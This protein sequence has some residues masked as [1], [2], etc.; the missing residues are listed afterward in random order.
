MYTKKSFHACQFNPLC[1]GPILDE[2]PQLKMLFVRTADNADSLLRYIIMVYDPKS[3]M[4]TGER[5]VNKRKELAA[6]MASLPDDFDY[7]FM[8]EIVTEYL[9]TFS[10]SKEWAAIC[11][12]EFKFWESITKLMQPIKPGKDI[13]ELQAVQKKATISEEIEK[14]IRRLESYYR[15]FYGEDEMLVKKAGRITP[16]GIAGL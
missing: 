12:L 2:Y 15:T 11:A 9:K 6:K 16:E 13:E 10:R 3:P 8:P 7:F 5:D 4:V 14:D 1:E